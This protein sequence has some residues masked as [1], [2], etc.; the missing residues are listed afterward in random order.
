MPVLTLREKTSV[1][2]RLRCEVRP[3]DLRRLLEF[4]LQ[5]S[6]RVKWN[7]YRSPW[8]DANVQF[9]EVGQI[10]ALPDCETSD[11]ICHECKAIFGN[12]SDR[13]GVPRKATGI[14]VARRPSDGNDGS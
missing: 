5:R 11:L 6:Q 8:T 12:D 2:Q 3:S 10:D 13:T 7:C 14:V 9:L 4:N 1:G